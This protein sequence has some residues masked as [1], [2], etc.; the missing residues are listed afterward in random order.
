[1]ISIVTFGRPSGTSRIEMILTEILN[2]LLTSHDIMAA[3][4]LERMAAAATSVMQHFKAQAK[5]RQKL[6]HF[7]I[8]T[9]RIL[10][11]T[12]RRSQ[13][14]GTY[15]LEGTYVCIDLYSVLSAIKAIKALWMSWWMKE[16]PSCTHNVLK[17]V[18]RSI[19]YSH[20]LAL[21]QY[22]SWI[23]IDSWVR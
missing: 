12:W 13:Y 21:S 2:P 22:I 10:F 16:P 1:M 18:C 11:M 15:L 4:N 17:I 9:S 14:I 8:A 3:K 19:F 23:L 5:P 7:K 6:T 20:E